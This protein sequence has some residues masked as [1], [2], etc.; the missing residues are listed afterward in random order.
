MIKRNKFGAAA[1]CA[2]LLVA[3]F[4]PA[5]SVAASA[6]GSHFQQDDIPSDAEQAMFTKGQNLYNQGRY[7]QAVT[8]YEQ[9][10]D[11]MR[12]LGDRYSQATTLT[13]LGGTHHTAGN[14]AAAR[15]AWQQALTILEELDHPDAEAV[16]AKLHQPDQTP[17]NEG[18]SER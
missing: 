8:C 7:D 18:Q 16:R 4:A 10:L 14:L 3:P 2:A 9:A 17:P 15:G 1:L 13:D 12:D 11:L 5:L 6:R